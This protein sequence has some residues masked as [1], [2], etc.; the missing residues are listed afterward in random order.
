MRLSWLARG[1]ASA[2][3][4]RRLMQMRGVTPSGHP[5]WLPWECS[6]LEVLGP[7]YSIIDPMLDRRS[8][9]A[10]HSKTGRLGVAGTRPPTWTDNELIR[11]RKVYPKG[12]RAEIMVALPGRTWIAIQRKAQKRKIRRAKQPEPPTGIRI[13][14]QILA[15]A[16]VLAYPLSELDELAKSGTY[17]RSRRWRARPDASIHCRTA[18]SLGG[19]IRARFA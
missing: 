13:L 1:A 12:S 9:T 3:R 7:S 18:M 4:A 19:T 11:L 14:D 10:I 16:E 17:F 6:P 15:R 8:L 5:L 2:E